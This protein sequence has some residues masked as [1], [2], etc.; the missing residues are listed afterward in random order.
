[1][2]PELCVIL[3]D[4][5]F[6][7]KLSDEHT[8]AMIIHACKPPQTNA[9]SI[10]T[11]GL[12]SLGFAD[13]TEPL[14]Q[15]GIQMSTAMA[16]VPGRILPPPNVN[17][18]AGG[19]SPNV[20]E[21]AAWNLQG[22]KFLIGAEIKAPD[23]WAALVIRDGGRDD[24][25]QGDELNG[26]LRGF[27]D[28]CNKSGMGLPFSLLQAPKFVDLPPKAFHDQTRR[29]AV[30]KIATTIR[31]FSPK[32]RAILIFLSSGDKSIYSGI[33]HVC[34][35]KL[36]VTTVCVQS[37]KIRKERGQPQY[38]ANVAL[39]LN[40]KLNGINHTLDNESLRWLKEKPTMLIGSDVT[41]PSPG[42]VRGTPSIAAVVGS[43]DINFGQYPASLRLQES[44]KEVRVYYK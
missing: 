16:V 17:Y 4:Q 43:T 36:D 40:M 22:V 3:P 5:A 7:G 2:P 8:A 19:N 13:N 21:G 11:Q 1:M 31:S 32:P 20:R 38:F 33:K 42:S 12:P 41:H 10:V 30:E 9:Q 25:E 26:I 6:R 44:K 27:A 39:K 18:R 37:Q 29:T 28:M 34:D 15:F 24:L 23:T 14:G 35:T